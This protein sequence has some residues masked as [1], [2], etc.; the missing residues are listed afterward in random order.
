MD[1]AVKRLLGYD[2]EDKVFVKR[3]QAL[4][5]LLTFVLLF[6]VFCFIL[7]AASRPYKTEIV[8]KVILKFSLSNSRMWRLVEEVGG[9][10]L[11]CLWKVRDF[12]SGVELINRIHKVTEGS[13]HFPNLHLEQPDH[14]PERNWT[15]G[16]PSVWKSI[17]HSS[18]NIIKLWIIFV[19]SSSFVSKE[20]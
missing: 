6:T 10:K 19:L 20:F 8:V 11:Q 5:A 9:L 7:W 17:C 12:S 1:F 13:G 14:Q 18:H 2:D 4:I 16:K 3:F 15:I